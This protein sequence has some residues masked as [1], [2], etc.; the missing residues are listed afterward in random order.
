MPRSPQPCAWA[1]SPVLYSGSPRRSDQCSQ[2]IYNTVD[3]GLASKVFGSQIDFVRGLARNA[4]YHP[5]SKRTVL[6]RQMSFGVMFRSVFRARSPT[7]MRPFPFRSGSLAAAPEPR[8]SENQ[9]GRATPPRVPLGGRALL[10]TRL[11]GASRC[12]GRTS[13]ACCSMTWATFSQ[14]EHH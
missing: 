5:I 2:G 14:S 12:S 9:A 10:S 8:L 3:L 13:V 4:T 6:A 11:N 1:C 7:P